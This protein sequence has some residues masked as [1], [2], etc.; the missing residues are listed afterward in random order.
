MP[1]R[2]P[3]GDCDLCPYTMNC[4]DHVPGK[5]KC[6]VSVDPPPKLETQDDIRSLQNSVVKDAAITLQRGERLARLGVVEMNQISDLRKQVFMFTR[7]MLK[8]KGTDTSSDP[9]DSLQKYFPNLGNEQ[10]ET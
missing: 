4:P 10:D 5:A 6:T 9:E 7:D 8:D 3:T 2:K 1:R